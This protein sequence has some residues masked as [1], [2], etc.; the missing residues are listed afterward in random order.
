MISAATLEKKKFFL[1]KNNLVLK[2]NQ[3]I[4]AVKF[5]HF[6]FIKVSNQLGAN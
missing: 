3:V 6:I 5:N 2:S 4:L 1:S